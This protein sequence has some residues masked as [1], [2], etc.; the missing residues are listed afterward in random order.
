MDGELTEHPNTRTK[1]AEFESLAAHFLI[2]RGAQI[3]AR[4]FQCRSGELDLVALIGGTLVFVEVRFRVNSEYGDP[5]ETITPA[6]QRKLKRAA[7][8]FFQRN[9]HW[10]AW[11]CRFDVVAILPAPPAPN[12]STPQGTIHLAEGYQHL[13]NDT[14]NAD[15]LHRPVSNDS[16]SSKSGTNG[17]IVLPQEQTPPKRQT[18]PQSTGVHYQIEWVCDAFQV[19]AW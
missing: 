1:G 4:N 16:I 15:F 5:L 3:I 10:E 6:K 11:P 7:Q 13:T 17:S 18:P 9:P 2:E 12:I 19:D 14:P 8:V